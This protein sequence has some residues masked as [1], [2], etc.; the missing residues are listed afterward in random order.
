MPEVN[1]AG[2]E[3]LWWRPFLAAVLLAGDRESA[4]IAVLRSLRELPAGGIDTYSLLVGSVAEALRMQREFQAIDERSGADSSFL[5]DAL[6]QVMHLA[7]LPRSCFVLRT[8]EGL[9][10]EICASML[11]IDA[12]AVDHHA[13]MAAISLAESS[14]KDGAR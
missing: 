14:E 3:L 8:L 5:P 9:P 7:P 10:R 13:G 6:G 1:S 11:G 2:L 12:E 4:E